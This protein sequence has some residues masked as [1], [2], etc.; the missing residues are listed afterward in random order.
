M[1]QHR[2][3]TS[4]P[5]KKGTFWLASSVLDWLRDYARAAGVSQGAI[6]NALLFRFMCEKLV[7]GSYREDRVRRI[8]DR[9]AAIL[10]AAP[11]L[12]PNRYLSLSQSRAE[13]QPHER[14]K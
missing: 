9:Q 5:L 2:F 14:E 3:S 11:Q 6:I 7:P 10:G 12:R 4:D 13:G 1:N 8:L